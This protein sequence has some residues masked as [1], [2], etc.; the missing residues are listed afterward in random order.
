MPLTTTVVKKPVNGKTAPP[1]RLPAQSQ[2]R[3]QPQPLRPSPKG[4]TLMIHSWYVCPYDVTT[5]GG[6]VARVPAI[7]RHIP[8]VPGPLGENWDEAE[9]LG[10]HVVVKVEAPAEVHA[11]IRADTD[12]R[13]IPLDMATI[14]TG[15]RVALRTYLTGL[16]YTL[17]EVADTSWSV[18]QILRLLTTAASPLSVVAGALVVGAG[19]RVAP[20]TVDRIEQ[21]LPTSFDDAVE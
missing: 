8:V 6:L 21:L 13:R 16:G 4:N 1:S 15:A 10:N 2:T 7:K 14:P 5:H 19:R 11:L 18:T 12:F 17:A 9:I 3:P 20:K